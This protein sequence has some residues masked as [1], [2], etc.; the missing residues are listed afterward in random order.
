MVSGQ[1]PN[2]IASLNCFEDPSD[3][4]LRSTLTT[5]SHLMVAFTT[6]SP[7]LCTHL[8]G[9]ATS[10]K[11]RV[12]ARASTSISKLGYLL[13]LQSTVAS[14]SLKGSITVRSNSVFCIKGILECGFRG[15][16]T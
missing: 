9:T 10:C 15:L 2:F 3:G 7:Q 8:W 12:T 6:Y 5:Y 4:W 11:G 14:V 13:A 16:K 1:I